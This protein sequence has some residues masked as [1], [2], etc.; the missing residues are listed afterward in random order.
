VVVLV[1]GGC[2]KS[3]KTSASNTQAQEAPAGSA[4]VTLA[5][6][7]NNHGKADVSSKGAKADLDVEADDFYFSPTFVKAAPGQT[8]SITVD[9]HSKNTHTFT[10]AGGVD[11]QV[12]AGQKKA[13]TVTAPATGV[14][15]WYCRFH[16]SSG[17]QGA[18]Y[19]KDGD[20]A[21]PSS[22]SSSSTGGYGY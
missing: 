2:G 15:V 17:M 6:K 10:T 8:L 1:A 12:A 21:G 18:V 9:N 13:V 22:S 11:E 4:P 20:T 7:T 14:L 19:L 5:G 3:N 16:Q